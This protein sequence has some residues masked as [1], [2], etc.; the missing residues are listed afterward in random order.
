[1]VW[2]QFF[3]SAIYI[4]LLDS[5]GI[6]LPFVPNKRKKEMN[7]FICIH[8]VCVC[9][10]WSVDYKNGSKSWIQSLPSTNK[11]EKHHLLKLIVMLKPTIY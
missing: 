2:S 8:C 5:L 1:M 9:M 3:F 4:E 7:I 6:A 11:K 10:G